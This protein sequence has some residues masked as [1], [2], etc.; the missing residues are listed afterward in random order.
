MRAL[1]VIMV[2]LAAVEA[3]GQEQA[4]APEATAPAVTAPAV[5]VVEQKAPDKREEKT[6]GERDMLADDGYVLRLSLPTQADFDG[7]QESG[8][9]VSLAYLHGYQLGFA[10][11]PSFGSAGAVLRTW[12]RLDPKWS[13]GTT[14]SYQF[15]L[16][17]AS[18]V[19]WGAT[20][21][22]TFHVWRGLAV[23]AG[24]GYGGFM[25]FRRDP[26]PVGT[27]WEADPG[28]ESRTLRDDE[29][30]SSC[31]GGA[32]T[33]LVRAEYQFV[34]GPLF[35]T[36]PFAQTDVQWTRCGES[37][38]TS[39]ETGLAIERRQ[40]WLTQGVNLGWWLTWR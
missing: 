30:L 25:I 20:V 26:P 36:G 5:E 39:V 12:I 33:G 16:G 27:K 34:I 3:R 37:R 1:L 31:Q 15:G 9:R 6:V 22:P 23:T 28:V 24:L 35:S 19:K 10:P 17:N 8:F 38:G 4:A 14:F 40:W 18:G 13:I 32:W 21:E 29:W 11:A 7:W 2:M